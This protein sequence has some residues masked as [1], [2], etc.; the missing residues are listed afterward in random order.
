MRTRFER[1]R[2]WSTWGGLLADAWRSVRAGGSRLIG[3][4]LLFHLAILVIGFPLIGWLFREALRAGGM[5]AIDF[6][7]LKP[8]GG[9]GVT[10]LLV[11]VIAVLAFWI[12][13]AQFA[14]IVIAL[15]RSRLG[16]PLGAGALLRD[17]GG[18]ARKLLRPSSLPLLGYLFVL[19]PLTGFGFTSV[20]AQGIAVPPFISGELMKSPGTSVAWTVLMLAFVVLNV[21]FAL[22]VPVFVLTDATGWRSLRLSWRIT[23]GL[24]VI[25]LLGAI[26]TIL[27]AAAIATLAL[28]IAALVP[29]AIADEAAPD[30]SPVVAAFSLGAAQLTGLLLTSLVTALVAAVL[31]AFLVRFAERLPEPFRLREPEPGREPRIGRRAAAILLAAGAAVVALALGAAAIPTM[32][33]LSEHPETLVL[34][35]RGFGEGGVENTVCGLEAAAR[36]G[37]DLVE[38][39]VMQTKDGRF[40][41]MHDAN[42]SRLAGQDVA[43]KDLTLDELTGITVRDLIGHECAIPSLAEY[44][45]RAAD[46][47]MP[48]LIEIKLGGAD[49][50]DHVERLVAEL[51]SLGALDTNIYHTLDA[52]SAAELKRLRPDLTVGYIMP[53]AGLGVPDTTA[54][55]IVVEEWSATEDMQRDTAA[56]GLGFLAWTVNGESGMR[57]HLRRGTDGIISDHPDVALAAREEMDEETGLADTLIDALTRFVVV[58]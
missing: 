48:L 41:V 35:H 19:L 55:F 9:L 33:R 34:A 29:T 47:G 13:S 3:L 6:G 4:M 14:V 42:L 32:H 46:L 38:M 25:P 8:S 50:P 56:A 31:V 16:L 24:A 1:P 45:T 23:R 11:V 37:A 44:V 20:L 51:E 28:V 58:F 27:V 5:V 39:D 40:V 18:V 36:T 54:D 12:V 52:A 49:T 43:V 15:R 7:A 30:A 2:I 17:L 22:T 21:R 10:L 57:E 26:L 53:F